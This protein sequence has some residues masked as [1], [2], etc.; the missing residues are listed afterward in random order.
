MPTVARITQNAMGIWARATC[1]RVR[2]T[3]VR[4]A[5]SCDFSESG[6]RRV[7]V[8]PFTVHSR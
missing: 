5:R 4:F 7:S 1:L 8:A 6:R 2:R 3:E